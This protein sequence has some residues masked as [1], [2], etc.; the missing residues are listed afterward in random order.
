MKMTLHRF[1]PAMLR[2]LSRIRVGLGVALLSLLAA[3]PAVS[4]DLPYS[5]PQYP[6]QTGF[7]GVIPPNVMLILDDSGSMSW[8]VMPKNVTWVADYNR[9]K[10]NYI[11]N[12]DSYY[13]TPEYRSYTHNVIYYNPTTTYLPWRKGAVP[14]SEERL[15]PAD[16]RAV[17]DNTNDLTGSMDLR[18]NPNAYFYVPKPGI[19]YPGTNK[20][21]YSKYRVASSTAAGNYNGAI[22]QRC[23]R[24]DSNCTSENHWNSS[25]VNETPTGRSQQDEVQNFANWFHYHS[26]R[27]KMAKA[28]ASEAF[29]DLD[30]Q[31]RVGFHRIN[32]KSGVNNIVYRIPYTDNNGAFEGKNRTEFFDKLQNQNATGGTPLRR[33]LNTIG[34]YF[35][36]ADPYKNSDGK[37][38]SCRKNFAILTTDGAW[39]GTQPSSFKTLAQIA[40]YYW[41][42]DL[43][44]DLTNDVPTSAEDS[45]NWQHMNTFGISIGLGGNFSSAPQPTGGSWPNPEASASCAAKRPTPEQTLMCDKEKIDDLARAA[46]EGRGKFILANNTDEFAKALHD[47]LTS[48]GQRTAS[49]SSA[50]SSSNELKD[51]T[52]DFS[53]SFNSANWVGDISASHRKSD[54]ATTTYPLNWVI[55]GTFGKSSKTENNTNININFSQRTILT[56]YG[57]SPQ[58][59]DKSTITGSEFKRDGVSPVSI[60]DNIDYL[61]GVQTLESTTGL[62]ERPWPLGDIVNSTPFYAKDT[63]TVYIGANDGMLH[64]IHSPKTGEPNQGKVLFSY[65]PGGLDFEALAGLSARGYSHRFFVDGQIDVSTQE[66]TPNKNILIAATGRGARGVF[67]LDVTDPTNMGTA[68][69]LWDNT[70]QDETNNLDMGYVLSRIRIRR[71]NG[72]KTWALVPNGIESPNGKAVLFAYELNADGTIADIHNLK[73]NDETDNGLMALGIADLNGDSLI[74]IVYGGDLQGNVWRWDFSEDKPGEATLLFKAVDHAGQP[75]AITGGITNSRSPD[76]D[77]FIGFAT[78]RFISEQDVTGADGA[79]Q[80]QTVYGVMDSTATINGRSALQERGIA[81]EGTV[82]DR[83]VRAFEAYSLLTPGTKG[84]YLDLP[85]LGERVVTDVV[86]MGPEAMTFTSM[87]PPRASGEMTCESASGSGWINAI[88]LFTGTGPETGSGYFRTAPTITLPNGDIVTVGSVAMPSDIPTGVNVKCDTDD[89]VC[90]VVVGDGS[91]KT[92]PGDGP[93]APGMACEEGA[94]LNAVRA[95]TRRILWRNI[96]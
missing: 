89:G 72:D 91:G 61:R 85:E 3:N 66:I 26:S 2:K 51:T 11:P 52:L 56:S 86:M 65:V 40:N 9:G 69:V 7:V 39:N 78:G 33:T 41:K 95:D 70:T 44:T 58:K 5:F 35:Q 18:N 34:Q 84:W 28:G 22:I 83:K 12:P 8:T 63:E 87:L 53:T 43:R 23:T 82:N 80:V 16:I 81:Y 60:A 21:N 4:A 32:A 94:K 55:S 45:A 31:F 74:D 57:G 59:F 38:L 50:A 49:G 47:A 24:S 17:A 93:C 27:L 10:N 25:S 37:M 77:L 19:A 46:G 15:P 20:N 79:H 13:D 64:A 29:A 30:H 36:E 54:T 42:E 88:N 92:E 96:R 67:A 14:E 76:G 90:D 1:I 73:T 6:L 68:Q 48:I 71:G 62:R 75:Q